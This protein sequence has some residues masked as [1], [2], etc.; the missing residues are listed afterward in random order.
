MLLYLPMFVG[1]LGAKFFSSLSY[2]CEMQHL[3]HAR[4]WSQQ[5]I[6][7]LFEYKTGH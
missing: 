1:I 5:P 6:K 2:R 4:S 7:L 3:S